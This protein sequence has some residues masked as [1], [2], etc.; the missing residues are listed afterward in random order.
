MLKRTLLTLSG[1]AALA[2]ALHLVLPSLSRADMKDD[3]KIDKLNDAQRAIYSL[4]QEQVLTV[5]SDLI[6]GHSDVRVA[7]DAR[8]NLA[9]MVYAA[10]DETKVFTVDQIKKGVVLKKIMIK[11]VAAITAPN[12]NVATGGDATMVVLRQYS[13]VEKDDFRTVGLHLEN[14]RNGWALELNDRSGRKPIDEI[15]MQSRRTKGDVEIDPTS[16]QFP[17][18]KAQGVGSI[19]FKSGGSVVE[20]IHTAEQPQ[21]GN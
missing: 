9:G 1:I 8:G 20:V 6:Q 21:F 13:I 12:V 16:P 2:G 18:A 19:Q 10:P 5:K 3:V 4:K 14:T 15:Y 11:T 17:S 7:V